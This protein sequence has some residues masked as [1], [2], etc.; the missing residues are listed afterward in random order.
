[1]TSSVLQAPNRPQRKKPPKQEEEEKKVEA[2]AKEPVLLEKTW[3]QTGVDLSSREVS[4]YIH[5]LSC[6]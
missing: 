1:M 6:F 5:I 4:T 3:R 2:K